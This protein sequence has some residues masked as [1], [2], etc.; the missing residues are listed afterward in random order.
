MQERHGVITA[1][2]VATLRSAH[3]L[4]RTVAVAA[5]EAVEAVHPR[6]ALV[7]ANAPKAH[8]LVLPAQTVPVA[9]AQ[10]LRLLG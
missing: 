8:Q 6:V 7:A 5:V 10:V 9:V 2:R 1:D 4:P 3:S